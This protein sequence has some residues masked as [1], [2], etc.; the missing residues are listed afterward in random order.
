VSVYGH[1]T[2]RT[3]GRLWYASHFD[4]VPLE[5]DLWPLDRVLDFRPYGGR[6]TVRENYRLAADYFDWKIGWQEL[7]LSGHHMRFK[8]GK[9]PCDYCSVREDCT[10]ASM[11]EPF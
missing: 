5:F 2:G 6:S 3:K 9:S 7:P 1:F 4:L 10:I 11:G 8:S